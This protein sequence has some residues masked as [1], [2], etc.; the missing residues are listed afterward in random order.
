M[1]S[2]TL[3]F[4]GSLRVSARRLFGTARPNVF[5]IRREDKNRW[6]CRAPVT[7]AH[8]KA[9]SE[10]GIKFMVQ[11]SP[12]RAYTDEQFALVRRCNRFLVNILM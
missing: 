7:P 12:R 3:L 11:S 8:V 10:E 1:V 5:G 9:L 6:E 2:L 4:C